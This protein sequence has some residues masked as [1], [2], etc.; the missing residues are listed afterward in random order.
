MHSAR[1]DP[2]V[3]VTLSLGEG[4]QRQGSSQEASSRT[5]SVFHVGLLGQYRLDCGAVGSQRTASALQAGVNFT[6]T[7]VRGGRRRNEMVHERMCC[8]VNDTNSTSFHA[9]LH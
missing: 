7:W 2:M 6:H 8:G 4:E 3:I 5:T 1:L 9:L